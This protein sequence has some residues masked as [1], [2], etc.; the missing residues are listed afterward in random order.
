MRL[1]DPSLPTPKRRPSVLSATRAG[2][3]RRSRGTTLN[4]FRV[5]LVRFQVL[6]RLGV[7]VKLLVLLVLRIAHSSLPIRIGRRWRRFP[8]RISSCRA[9]LR[10]VKH[11]AIFPLLAGSTTAYSTSPCRRSGPP[12]PTTTRRRNLPNPSRKLLGELLDRITTGAE[13]AAN[14][15]RLKARRGAGAVER[16]G[17]ENRCAFTGTLGSN[18]SPAA[19]RA[20]GRMR[21]R[22]VR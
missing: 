12:R 7:E 4:V 9:V 21:R 16:G 6:D 13:P 22:T 1:G 20:L 17:L 8:P 15:H 18:P 5:L 14:P 11:A 19:S 3:H 2:R 10:T